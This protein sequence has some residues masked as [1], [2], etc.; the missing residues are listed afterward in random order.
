VTGMMVFDVALRVL[1][2]KID[3]FRQECDL[4][5]GVSRV[6]AA[7]AVLFDDRGIAIFCYRHVPSP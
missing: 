5:R 3:P 6:R 1:G 4:D 2:K 7:L